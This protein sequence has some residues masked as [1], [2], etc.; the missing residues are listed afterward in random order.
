[1][2]KT[3][4]IYFWWKSKL[5]Q[6]QWKSRWRFLK[7]A[8]TELPYALA[9]PLLGI[10]LKECKSANNGDTFSRRFIMALCAL[11]KPWNQSRCPSNDD[12]IKEMWYI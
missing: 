3:N 6:P 8:K 9:L 2:G 12:Q 7:K 1:V 10:D 5:V 4:P 11:A